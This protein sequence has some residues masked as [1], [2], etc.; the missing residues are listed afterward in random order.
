MEIVKVTTDVPKDF[1]EVVDLVDAILVKV[2]SKASMAS[3]IGLLDELSKAAEGIDNVDD[4]VM[5]EYRDECTGYLVRTLML[6]LA[7]GTVSKPAA[8]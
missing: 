4:A 2:K 7:P 3:Y 8:K 6:R 1:K 5:G